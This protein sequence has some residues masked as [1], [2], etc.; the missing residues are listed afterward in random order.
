M[1]ELMDKKIIAIFA[2]K[3]CLT[4]P[5]LTLMNTE[6]TEFYLHQL[7]QIPPHT[8]VHYQTLELHTV[9]HGL[10]SHRQPSS[11]KKSLIYIM[12]EFSLTTK[13]KNQN[14]LFNRTPDASIDI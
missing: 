13:M 7:D 8:Q 6:K 5:M 10:S 3:F 1:F 14:F 12:P 4:G 2:E 9:Y 11:L